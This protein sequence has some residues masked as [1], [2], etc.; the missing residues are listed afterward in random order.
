M[1][2]LG[3]MTIEAKLKGDKID[4]LIKCEGEEVCDFI[5]PFLTELRE[6]LSAAGC[7]IDTVKCVVGHDLVKEKI[8]YYQSLVLYTRDVIDLFA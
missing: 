3:E 8:D 7:E 5:S 2:I 1:D 6:S 4:C